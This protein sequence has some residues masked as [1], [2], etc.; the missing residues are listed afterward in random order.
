MQSPI[1]TLLRRFMRIS[2]QLLSIFLAII[3]LI[4]FVWPTLAYADTN[5]TGPVLFFPMITQG[6]ASTPSAVPLDPCALNDQEQA[7]AEIIRNAPGQGRS[8]FTCNPTLQAVARNHAQ[9]MATR[10]FCSSTDP[11]GVGANQRARQAGYPLPSYYFTDIGA[12][13]VETT[14]CGQSQASDVWNG[15][16]P[17]DHFQGSGD[18][19]SKQIE[20]GIAYL[21]VP[22][23]KFGH[24]WVVVTA[25][26]GQ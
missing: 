7:L 19:W 3:T 12:N 2:R 18:F 17:N 26:R 6:H 20:F 8:T 13:N 10:D 5:T 21:Q 9:D 14:A 25:E 1:P 22:E 24:Y 4:C 11:T 15:Q 16:T 23:S